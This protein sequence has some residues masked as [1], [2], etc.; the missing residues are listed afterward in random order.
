MVV[1]Q[2]THMRMGRRLVEGRGAGNR[3]KKIL[4]EKKEGK[5]KVVFPNMKCQLG[6]KKKSEN[7]LFQNI[8]LSFKIH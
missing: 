4:E 1:G 6:R 3:G 8:T 5:K 2:K 7:H